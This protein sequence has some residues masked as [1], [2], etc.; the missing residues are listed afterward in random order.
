MMLRRSFNSSR[1]ALPHWK[2]SLGIMISVEVA[3][4]EGPMDE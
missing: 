1:P 4:W 2:V 3:V